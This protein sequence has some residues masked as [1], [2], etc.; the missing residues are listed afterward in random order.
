MKAELTQ[1]MMDLAKDPKARFIGYGLKRNGA[2][3]TLAGVPPEQII[4]TT[5]AENLMV[6]IAIGL[7]MKGY[8]P[9][10]FFER[11]DF[12]LNALD[13]IV[14]HGEKLSKISE[15]EFNPAIIYRCV[16]G[17]VDR[18]RFTGPTHTQDF[19]HAME[20]FG[21][22]VKVIR[23]SSQIIPAYAYAL[24]VTARLRRSVVIVE[25]KDTY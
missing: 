7:S 1:A 14:N 24:E 23:A 2:S 18:P 10:V 9:L 25:Y 12:I 21:L 8:K 22:D 17:N 16:V 4:E 13:A 6:G 5:V 3:G 15:E 20:A 19:T 11:F